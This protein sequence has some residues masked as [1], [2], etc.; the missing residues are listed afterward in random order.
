MIVYDPLPVIERLRTCVAPSVEG[1]WRADAVVTAFLDCNLPGYA[2]DHDQATCGLASLSA[3]FGSQAA[4]RATQGSEVPWMNRRMMEKALTSL[5]MTFDRKSGVMP[6]QGVVL[7]QWHGAWSRRN[8]RGRNLAYTHWVSVIDGYV[9]D[10]NWPGWLPFESWE[11]L[12][13]DEL[14]ER[15][16]AAGWDVLSGYEFLSPIGCR[17]K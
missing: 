16:R 11:R 17:K 6:D 1:Y 3:F 15:R 2:V 13:L 8:Y 14:L 12:V 9:F 10:V 5:G 7:L 4:A